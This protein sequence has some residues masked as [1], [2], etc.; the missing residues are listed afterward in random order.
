MTALKLLCFNYF[1]CRTFSSSSTTSSSS[2]CSPKKVSELQRELTNLGEQR[3][4]D[5][6]GK[7]TALKKVKAL[8]RD[9]AMA[10]SGSGN[11]NGSGGGGSGGGGS[12]GG[13]SGVG[14]AVTSPTSPTS[15]ASPSSSSSA[16]MSPLSPG[17]GS[18]N[19]SGNLSGGV[20]TR[21]ID[22]LR[23]ALKVRERKILTVLQVQHYF[24]STLS[25]ALSFRPIPST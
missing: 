14:R 18:S 12:G 20:D 22:E 9:L 1:V 15:P 23:R 7:T 4:V 3:R 24:H 6:E 16:P 21:N 19:T 5:R 8:E 17:T 10:T 11:G 2:C 25:S 13:G